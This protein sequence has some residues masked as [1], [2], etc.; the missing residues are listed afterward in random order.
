VRNRNLVLNLVPLQPLQNLIPV[1]QRWHLPPI[2]K[3]NLGLRRLDQHPRLELP[4]EIVSR[5]VEPGLAEESV[6]LGVGGV[7][8]CHGFH[9]GVPGGAAFVFGELRETGVCEDTA[10]QEVL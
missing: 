9:E 3:A 5:P 10:F 7:E 8:G 4:L 2:R 1:R 6:L